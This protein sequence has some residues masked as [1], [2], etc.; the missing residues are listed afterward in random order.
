M[1]KFLP[2]LAIAVFSSCTMSKRLIYLEK[3]VVTMPV[4]VAAYE[5]K[6]SDYDGVYLDLLEVVE[7]TGRRENPELTGGGGGWSFHH[8]RQRKYIV[9][10]PDAER[11]TTFSFRVE[12]GATLGLVYSRITSPDGQVKEYG[13]THYKKESDSDAATVYKFVYPDV[14]KGTIIEEGIELSYNVRSTRPPLAH[15]IPLQFDIPCEH[16]TFKYG[17]PDWW[18]I[19]TKRVSEFR[20]IPYTEE[21]DPENHKNIIT[22]EVNDVIGIKDEPYAPSFKEVAD[23][24]QFQVEDLMMLGFSYETPKS[25]R[26][27]AKRYAKYA[28][29]KGHLGYVSGPFYKSPKKLKELSK[30]IVEGSIDTLEKVDRIVSYIQE[31]IEIAKD[32]KERSL[33]AIIEDNKGDIYRITGLAQYLLKES[34][35]GSEYCLVHSSGDGFFDKDYISMEQLYIP[36]VRTVIDGRQYFLFPY[37][38]YLPVE[39]TPEH[40]QGEVALA[41]SDDDV[42]RF[43]EVPEGNKALNEISEDYEVRIAEDGLIRVKEKKIITGS[44]A[45]YLR[46]M[47][48][49]LKEDEV[50]KTMKEILTYDEGD[51]KLE[52]HTVSDLKSYKEPLEIELNYTIDNLISITPDE[53]LFQTG[54][55]FS[56]SS[57]KKYKV[58]SEERVNPIRVYYDEISRKNIKIFYPLAWN[59]D[60]PPDDFA[61]EN[62]FGAIKATYDITDPGVLRVA[63]ERVL[64]S[65]NE[66]KEAYG[67]FLEITGNR[68]RLAIPTI[69]FSVQGSN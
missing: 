67:E 47:L 24:F 17:Y 48:D 15:M 62:K 25:W 10:N 53:V 57:L 32:D 61:I 16:L 6:Y 40:L 27:V 54:G 4:D 45:Y 21:N 55:L 20:A 49:D 26:E 38:K 1:K 59:V 39:H 63:Q 18:K 44:I 41:I 3:P 37:L 69:V 5:E 28:G 30:R 65:S 31:N 14:Q 29:K 19:G 35:I 22:V 52:S 36:A 43:W 9:L 64:N 58:K 56:P 7:H 8:V 34:G 68:S 50:D 13:L 12:A 51:V 33:S 11:L 42:I 23:Y 2:L 66:P 60:S 46:K